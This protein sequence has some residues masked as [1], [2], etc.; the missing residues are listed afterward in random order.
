M[1]TMLLS[2]VNNVLGA[3][4]PFT[5][6]V[7]DPGPPHPPGTRQGSI[8][9][10]TM[11]ENQ[12]MMVL[13]KLPCGHISIHDSPGGVGSHSLAV[14]KG[15]L[16]SMLTG[17]QASM[18]MALFQYRPLQPVPDTQLNI[19]ILTPSGGRTVRLGTVVKGSG[20]GGSGGGSGGGGGGGGG[21]GGGDDADDCE[22]MERLPVPDM[23]FGCEVRVGVDALRANLELVSSTSDGDVTVEICD[24]GADTQLMLLFHS[25]NVLGSVDAYMFLTAVEPGSASGGAGAWRL[26]EGVVRSRLK[27]RASADAEGG[28]GAPDI[29]T[30][31]RLYT[32]VFKLG[33]LKKTL[34]FMQGEASVDLFL[35]DGREA[36]AGAGGGAAPPP[37]PRDMVVPLLL[38]LPLDY[39][40]GG[41]VACLVAPQT[42]EE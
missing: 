39:L 25:E 5:V 3:T 6:A 42:R 38:R 35:G 23:V 8:I 2:I 12:T 16:R 31:P 26:A 22:G 34:Q 17:A 33:V 37:P 15:V 9:I 11:A 27:C 28:R 21:E 32:D 1:F 20:A 36:G 29:D 24:L 10:K 41:Y 40:H 13:A 30:L 19:R 7:E 18:S 14:N 4:V